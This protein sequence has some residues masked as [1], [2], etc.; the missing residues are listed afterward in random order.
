MFLSALVF[1]SDSDL[2]ILKPGKDG[3]NKMLCA[4][5]PGR[6]RKAFQAFLCLQRSARCLTRLDMPALHRG[7]LAV[8]TFEA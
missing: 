5:T 4:M 7:G 1:G 8:G 3:G 2:S 6:Q